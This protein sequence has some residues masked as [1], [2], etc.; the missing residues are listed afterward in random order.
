METLEQ[1]VGTGN[2]LVTITADHG[3]AA[4]PELSGTH[5]ILL[6]KLL[7]LID[8]KFGAKISLGG[9]FVNLWFDQQTLESRG[10]THAQIA[11][12]LRS[13]TAG[14]YYGSKDSWPK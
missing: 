10:I 14:Q 11:D 3:M 5:R 4:L 9:G 13:L 6:S 8:E 7:E 1:R 2:Y 12:Y